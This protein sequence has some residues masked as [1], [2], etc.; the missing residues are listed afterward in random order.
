MF[1]E[2]TNSNA[3][4][5]H[6]ALK[7]NSTGVMSSISMKSLVDRTM[8]LSQKRSSQ[9][10]IN[11][12]RDINASITTSK[13]RI[14]QLLVRNCF[15]K[16]QELVE[17]A[18]KCVSKQLNYATW[19]VMYIRKHDYNY[20]QDIHYLPYIQRKRIVHFEEGKTKD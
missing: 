17:L 2:L 11:H 14:S 16:L 15:L 9:K 6:S 1:D 7:S 19:I 5:E 20:Q 8:L 13:C 12:C 3:E 10:L 4:S 18:T